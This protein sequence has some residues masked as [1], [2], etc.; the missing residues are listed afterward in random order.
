MHILT[1]S[2]PYYSP[3]TIFCFSSLLFEEIDMETVTTAAAAAAAP[4][5]AV[6][7]WSCCPGQPGDCGSGRSNSDDLRNSSLLRWLEMWEQQIC[8]L[9][10][11]LQPVRQNV[12]QPK[13]LWT[14]LH[15]LS[16]FATSFFHFDLCGCVSKSFLCVFAHPKADVAALNT[17]K[18]FGVRVCLSLC[19][20]ALM[21]PPPHPAHP[22]ITV[23]SSPRT[24]GKPAVTLFSLATVR[25]WMLRRWGIQWCETE[26]VSARGRTPRQVKNYTNNSQADLKWAKTQWILTG[27]HWLMHANGC[28]CASQDLVGRLR[29]HTWARLQ[30]FRNFLHWW[31]LTNSD[32][33]VMRNHGAK[34]EQVRRLSGC[35]KK[36]C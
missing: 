34:S 19:K 27:R 31:T 12:M 1:G 5:G 23:T 30:G 6:G 17:T 29:Q 24:G 14:I 21:M 4:T 36:Q 28:R 8:L 13:C 35:V 22:V 26:C 25:G 10:I 15:S 2:Q 20:I 16:P 7:P 33:A 32:G 3:C 18:P 11:C 9:Q